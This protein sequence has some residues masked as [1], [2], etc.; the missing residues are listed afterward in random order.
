M[1]V[2]KLKTS[3]SILDKW[4]QGY[5]EDAIAMI[6]GLEIPPTEAMIRGRKGHEQIARKQLNI[7]D[8]LSEETIFETTNHN[9]DEKDRINYFK[10]QIPLKGYELI[11]TDKETGEI[12]RFKLDDVLSFSGVKDI[13]DPKNKILLDWK[14]SRRPAS[15]QKSLQLFIYSY[16]SI[17]FEKL[18]VDKAVFAR[19]DYDNRN[20]IYCDEYYVHKITQDK[21]DFAKNF[22]V[23]NSLEILKFLNETRGKITEIK[24]R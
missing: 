24:V 2:K 11:Q 19:T 21:L 18:Q 7:V 23:K 15:Q 9:L 10:V 4:S 6:G 13:Y 8:L 3:W 12:E 14:F 17:E 20:Q 5:R 1:K 16:I 22:I